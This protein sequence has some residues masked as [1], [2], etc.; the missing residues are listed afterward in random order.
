MKNIRLVQKGDVDD[1]KE[2]LNTIELF[3][4][5]MLDDMIADYFDNPESEDIWF[6]SIMKNKPIAIGY[7]APEQ[8]TKGTF[9]LYALGVRSDVQASGIGSQMMTFIETYLRNKGHRILIVDTS[10]TEAFEK[11]RKFYQKLNYTK[12]AVIRDFWEDGDD[13]VIFWKRIDR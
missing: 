9:N 4:S 12:E 3:P 6:T 7:C 13:K 5:E 10:G 1:L 11:T 8:M 2:V